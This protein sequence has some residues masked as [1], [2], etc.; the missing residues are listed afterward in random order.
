MK[1][2]AAELNTQIA[3][4]KVAIKIARLAGN[5]DTLNLLERLLPRIEL[6][7]TRRVKVSA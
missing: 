6:E 4:M 1:L 2:T 5:H 3:A 7:A